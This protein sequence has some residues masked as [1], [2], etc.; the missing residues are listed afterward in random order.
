MTAKNN[1]ESRPACL[2]T[3][4]TSGIGLATAKLFAGHG[5]DIAICGRDESKLRAAKDQILESAGA[6]GHDVRCLAMTADLTDAEQARKFAKNSIDQ[7]KR[8]DVF[9]NN[10]SMAPLASFEEIT[11]ETFEATINIALR[12]LFYA[13]QIVWK[14]MKSQGNGVVVNISS[15]SAVD[16]FPGFSLYGACKAWLDLMTH[17]LAGEGKEHGLRVCSIRPG[18]VETPMLRGLFP[19]FPADQCVAP[20]AIASVVWGC[21]NEPSAYPSG[22][23]FPVTNQPTS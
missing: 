10:A 12:S 11:E 7:F 13:T 6:A 20:E 8:V 14:Q 18:A 15:L 2:I 9:V 22:Q 1:P 4:G 3:G 23:A 19:D 16:P 17:A 21:I 5:Y